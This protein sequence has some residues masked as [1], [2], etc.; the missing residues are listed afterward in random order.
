MQTPISTSC[1]L[2]VITALNRLYSLGSAGQPWIG[3][4][5]LDR[6]YSLGSAVQPWIGC[7]AL[8]RLY[9]G[10]LGLAE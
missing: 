1:L 8:D 4:T 6:L 3:W 10:A 2:R 9:S 5:A 7:T